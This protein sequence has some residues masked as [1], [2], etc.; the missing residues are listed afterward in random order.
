MLLTH[1]IA[2]AE[3]THNLHNRHVKCVSGH[4]NTTLVFCTISYVFPDDDPFLVET[5]R[6]NYRRASVLVVYIS[7]LLV[8]VL[9]FV[10][11]F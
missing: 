1:N 3:V 10:L 8:E 4:C 9:V 2:P 5:S 6:S 11:V 7:L